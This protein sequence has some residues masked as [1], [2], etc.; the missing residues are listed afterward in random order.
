MGLLPNRK[1]AFTLVELL[2]VIT[3]I[4]I[5]AAL[6]LGAL[7]NAKAKA[8]STVC[9]N[10]LRQLGIALRLYVDDGRGY[11]FFRRDERTSPVF[12]SDCLRPYGAL[13]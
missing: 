10:N 11:P 2:T 5:L 13:A 12:S 9:K 8:Q 7:A 6:L 1:G 3:V 4:A